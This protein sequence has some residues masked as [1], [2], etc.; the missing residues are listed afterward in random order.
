MHC[1][2]LRAVWPIRLLPSRGSVVVNTA[3]AIGCALALFSGL[4]LLA[5]VAV[6]QNAASHS[7]MA[8]VIGNAKYPLAALNDTVGD[9]RM[10]QAALRDVGFEVRFHDNLS[11]AD[12]IGEIKRFLSASANSKIRF[13][14]FAGHG[15]TYRGRNYMIP[16][17]AVL[18][19][20]DEL[21]RVGVDLH[22][23][24]ERLVGIGNG[25]SILVVDA[26][27]SMPLAAAPPDDPRRLILRGTTRPSGFERMVAPRGTL[28]A[29]STSP[30]RPAGIRNSHYAKRL[31][32]EI[33]TPGQPVEEVF[34]NVRAAVY[35]DTRGRQT[36]WEDT[37]LMGVFCFLPNNSARCVSEAGAEPAAVLNFK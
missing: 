6:A 9:A 16:V 25:V 27:R 33:R 7:R 29:Y 3:A 2:S 11:L 28:V 8:M 18:R 15:A 36:P 31:A 37:S 1:I 30:G 5:N 17:D 20:E 14:Y 12:F 19:S 34:K 23:L 24:Q 32:A 10:I 35:Q 4:L 22:D 13:I 26:C 21:P